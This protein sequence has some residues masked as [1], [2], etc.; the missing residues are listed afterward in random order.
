MLLKHHFSWLI[1]IVSLLLSLYKQPFLTFFCTF[2][3][4]SKLFFSHQLAFILIS[5]FHHEIS[6]S[7]LSFWVFEPTHPRRSRLRNKQRHLHLNMLKSYRG[8]WETATLTLHFDHKYFP[9]RERRRSCSDLS[10]GA[11]WRDHAQCH[12]NK[13]A[14]WIEGVP[15]PVR[16]LAT[17][18]KDS[19][20]AFVQE[21][22]HKCLNISPS[23]VDV[24]VI[25]YIMGICHIYIDNQ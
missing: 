3:P 6:L 10:T 2:L 22:L 24:N 11:L 5:P 21:T 20:K 12:L 15:V 25:I 9:W 8:M 16:Q 1:Y 7:R 14:E 18:K 23:L 4:L 17:D 19:L 13:E